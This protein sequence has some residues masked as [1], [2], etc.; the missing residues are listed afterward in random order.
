ML[1]A[2]RR[3]VRIVDHVLDSIQDVP[4][5]LAW[6]DDFKGGLKPVEPTENVKLELKSGQLPSDLAG[7]YMRVGPNSS[8]WPPRK[9]M[10]VFDGDGMVHSIRIING[11]A[12]YHCKYLET[13]RYK[14]ERELGEEWFPRIGEFHGLAGLAK[15]IACAGSKNKVAGLEDWETSLANTAI[16]YNPAGK[17]WALHEQGPPF[18][19]RLDENGIP[20]SLGYDTLLDSHK[21][22]VSAHPKID[23]RTG[24]I[25]FHGREIMKSFYVARVTDGQV[26]ERADLQMHTGFHHDMFITEN[27][28]VIIDGSMQFDR[29][30]LVKGKPLWKFTPQHKLRFGLFPRSAGELRSDACVWIEAP[31]AAEIV[32]MLYAYDEGGKIVL[33][34]PLSYY[35]EGK[36]EGIL[37]GQGPSWMHRL[38]IDIDTKSVDVQK[39]QGGDKHMTEFPRIR[40]DRIGLRTRYGYSGLQSAGADFNFTGML[41]WDF[42]EGRLSSEINF[43]KNVIGGEPVFLPSS[44]SNGDDDDGYIGLFLWDPQLQES[45]WALFDA[46]SFSSTPV[47]ELRVPCRVPLGFHAA[48][49]NEDQFQKQLHTP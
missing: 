16:A 26:V 13:P 40:D 12:T 27:F 20:S 22:P 28:V 47:A 11:S 10:H 38:I 21:K 35:Q 46:Q 8:F 2:R 24:D 14:F 6:A 32:H 44:S 7:A 9:R 39:V 49:I 36:E 1:Q 15:I 37:G 33:W 5:S 18:R 29:T 31:V 3:L 42:E 48:W 4:S 41:K 17:L 30:A 45:T 34:A 25:F 43:P 19:F 23:C